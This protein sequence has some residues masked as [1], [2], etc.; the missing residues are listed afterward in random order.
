MHTRRK[1]GDPAAGIE[2]VMTGFRRADRRIMVRIDR[3]PRS[4]GGSS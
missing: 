3:A 4:A 2:A 1:T